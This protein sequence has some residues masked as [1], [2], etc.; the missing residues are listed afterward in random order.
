MQNSNHNDE[1]PLS[2]SKFE[3]FRKNEFGQFKNEMTGFKNE[4]TGFKN[5]MTGFKN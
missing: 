4:M 3:H 2:E 5:E 1:K